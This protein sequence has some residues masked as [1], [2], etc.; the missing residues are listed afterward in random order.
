MKKLM[1]L[2]AAVLTSLM[3]SGCI[4]SFVLNGEELVPQNEQEE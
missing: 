1:T 3:L 4:E 2:A